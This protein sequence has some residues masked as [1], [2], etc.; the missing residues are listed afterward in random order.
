MGIK[1]KVEERIDSKML[2]A[3]LEKIMDRVDEWITRFDDSKRALRIE[4]MNVALRIP[5]L[6]EAN[7]R[8]VRKDTI[9]SSE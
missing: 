4:E 9:T 1:E 8:F 2:D 7:I 6:G 5:Q 3:A